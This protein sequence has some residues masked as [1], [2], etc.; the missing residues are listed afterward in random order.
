LE[1]GDFLV[2]LRDFLV[3]NG[4]QQDFWERNWDWIQLR[5]IS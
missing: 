4:I 5:E 2:V 3:L 1:N